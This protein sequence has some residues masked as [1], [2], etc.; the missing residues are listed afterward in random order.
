MM[1]VTFLLVFI[2]ISISHITHAFDLKVVDQQ[3]INRSFS[4]NQ[5]DTHWVNLDVYAFPQ[6]EDEYRRLLNDLETAQKLL[7][8]CHIRIVLKNKFTLAGD[9]AFREYESLEFNGDK[10]SPYEYAIFNLVPKFSTGIILV[11]SLDW[12]IGTDGTVAVGYAPYILELELLETQEEQE[13]L[14][15]KMS[16]YS[17]LG[18]ARSSATL[19]HELGHSLF[20]LRHNPDP[21]N[22]MYPYGFGRSP[23][24]SFSKSQCQ[25]ARM[26]A[27][28]VKPLL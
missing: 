28:W 16:G 11:E 8:K 17:V 7:S 18:K 13:F 14:L 19:A 21:T 9:S 22:I 23:R 10:I 26:N 4:I 24:A 15:H 1:K 27:P 20:S 3:L 12:T 2:F 6:E 25:K 5:Q